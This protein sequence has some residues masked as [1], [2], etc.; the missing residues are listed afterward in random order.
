[1]IQEKENKCLWKDFSPFVDRNKQYKEQN[2]DIEIH[3][4]MIV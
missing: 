1:M 3:Y 4:Y 2:R